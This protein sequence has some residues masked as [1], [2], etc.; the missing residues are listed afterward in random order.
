M[1]LSLR[2]V[3]SRCTALLAV[4]VML[5]ACQSAPAQ[6]DFDA[7]RDYGQY[8]NWSWA[9]P[10]VQYT[11]NDDPR[12]QS[13]LTTQRVREAVSG[14]L[15]AR[16]LRPAQVPA[17]ADLLV[18]V[19]VISE[20]RRDNV[21]TTFG[22]SFGGYWGGWGG[23]PGFAETRS[24]DHQV[25]TL[26]IDL[27]DRVDGQLVW[28]GSD[29]QQMRTTPQSPAERSKLIQSMVSRILGGFPPY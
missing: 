17:E 26:Q 11:P 28:R 25:L 13:D 6:R 27:L 16:G 20:L 9:E 19:Y 29:E 14:Q 2:H 21:T 10:D 18:R 15:D 23:G 22:G 12:I 24:V 4:A 1:L 8:R 3:A 7:N 5:S